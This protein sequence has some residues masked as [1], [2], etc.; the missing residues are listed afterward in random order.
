M[1][2]DLRDQGAEERD[3]VFENML[4]RQQIF[5][6]Y[7]EISYAMDAGDIGRVEMC[8]MPW[9]WIFQATGK[10]R[11]ATFM[12]KYLRDVHTR[13]PEGLKQAIRRNILVNPTG[14]KGRFRGVDWVVEHNNLYSKRIYGGRFS[15]HTKRRI[16]KESS[17]LGVFKSARIMVNRIFRIGRR[18]TRHSGPNL[19]KTF[20]VIKDYIEEIQLNEKIH[21][22][23]TT[24]AI[25]NQIVRGQHLAM[26]SK[27]KPVR[28][29]HVLII[30]DNDPN[31]HEWEDIDDGDDNELSE[32]DI[33]D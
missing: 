17:L 18:T 20:R 13:Y 23:H 28:G 2:A 24:Y 9:I 8:F 33:S 29:E 27:P 10:H 11:Y 22:R 19:R 26:T 16:I 5:L 31:A 25:P 21:G 7:E 30:S 4:I 12:R 14:K 32:G 6:L 3:H 1:V 15:N